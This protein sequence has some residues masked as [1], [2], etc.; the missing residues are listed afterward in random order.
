MSLDE[1]EE[2]DLI[3]ELQQR[4]KDRTNSICDYCARPNTSSPCNEPMRHSG[5]LD[6]VKHHYLV[7]RLQL[8]FEKLLEKTA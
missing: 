8:S 6:N 2:E 3:R 4:V 1:F 5:K 7:T